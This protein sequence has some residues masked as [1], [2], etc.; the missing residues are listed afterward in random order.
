MHVTVSSGGGDDHGDTRSAATSL[1]VGSSRSG[2]IDPG[3]DIDYFRVQVNGSGELTVGTSGST[4][5]RGQL[6]DSAGARLASDD[7]GGGGANF[8]IEHSVTAGTYYIQVRGYNSSTTG[9]YTLH[10]R[11]FGGSGADDH[12]NIRPAAT[13][14]ALGSATAGELSAAD[15]DYFRVTM[16]SSGVLLVYTTGATDTYGTLYDATGNELTHNDDGGESANFRLVA[17]VS[18]GTYYIR[19]RGYDPSETGSYTLRVEER[20]PSGV[21]YDAPT[22]VR[23][24]DDRVVVIGVPGLLETDEIDF[25]A[26][27]QVFFRHYEDAFD[28]LMFFGNLSDLDQNLAYDYFGVHLPVQN[29]VQGTGK[30]IHSRTQEVGS[31]GR[32]NAILH[33]PYNWALLDGP[34]L[35]EIL[36]SWANYAIPTVVGGHWG[37]SS[38]DGQLGGFGPADLVDHGGGRY[39]AGGFGT[40]ANGGNSL[41][42]SSIELYFAGLISP[43]EVPDL[44]VAEDGA[45]LVENGEGVQDDSGHPI[46]TASRVSTWSVDRI[47][48]EHGARV[49]D[50][51]NS[52][53]SFRAAAILLVD[54]GHPAQQSTLDAMSAAVRQFSHAGS[55]DDG[56]FNFWE[57][58]GGRA[59]LAMDGL[60]TYRK[61]AAGKPTVSYRIVE[62]AAG[63]DGH[64]GCGHIGAAA[65]GVNWMVAPSDTGTR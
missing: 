40:F 35:H 30:G 63:K 52:Q 17:L 61:T 29:L 37:F 24:Y 18:P 16:N 7:D 13:T 15:L 21:A 10:S 55:D 42:Y 59:T 47:V 20:V 56:L 8:L 48:S 32:L 14:V 57:A 46:F 36:H 53:K 51:R 4:D 31:A 33:F 41:P 12:G 54:Q 1:P 43:S 22:F 9:S 64:V 11:F 27:A 5:T 38:A 39:S 26:A 45:W 23:Q 65:D 2:R 58:A 25:D 50:S 6:L 49:P 62:P 19:V 60:S 44:W 28:Y 3:G 34:S